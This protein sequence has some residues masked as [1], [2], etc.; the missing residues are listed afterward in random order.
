MNS[1]NG[2]VLN[3]ANSLIKIIPYNVLGIAPNTT[4]MLNRLKFYCLLTTCQSLMDL[5]STDELPNWQRGLLRGKETFRGLELAPLYSPLL[6]LCQEPL[7]TKLVFAS[8]II[9]KHQNQLECKSNLLTPLLFGCIPLLMKGIN[10][11]GI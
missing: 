10:K 7:K 2:E 9:Y 11:M 3:F 1:E 5:I 4:I 8:R 6:S